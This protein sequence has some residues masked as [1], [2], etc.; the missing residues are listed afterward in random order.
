MRSLAVL[1][2][3]AFAVGVPAGGVSAGTGPG[4]ASSIGVAFPSFS[5]TAGDRVQIPFMF[6]VVPE[7][8]FASLFAVMVIFLVGTAR[9]RA[10]LSI[11][12][13]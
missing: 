12:L 8:G 7:P 6:L 5:L 1:T 9:K 11:S 13:W 4:V 10:R 3:V 2:V